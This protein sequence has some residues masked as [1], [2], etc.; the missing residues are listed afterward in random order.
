MHRLRE[1]RPG[2]P[3]QCAARAPGSGAKF[4]FCTRL[5][6]LHFWVW[7]PDYTGIYMGTNPMVAACNRG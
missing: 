2:A 1:A 7:Y 5:I 3:T 4:N 6:T